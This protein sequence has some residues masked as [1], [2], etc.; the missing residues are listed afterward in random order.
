MEE[1]NPAQW[2]NDEARMLRHEAFMTEV[3]RRRVR[4][5]GEG[6]TKPWWQRFLE[7]TGGAAMI[8]VL[9]GGLLGQL[10]TWSV[11]KGLKERE[12]QEAW[13]KARGDQ[14]LV[15]YKDYLNQEQEIVRRVYEIVGSCI[16]VS[17]DLIDLT[18]LE[19]APGKSI[20]VEKQRNSIRERYNT[21]DAQWRGEREKLG[22]L[23]S[24][25]HR[26][27][28]EVAAAWRDLQDSVT[29]YNECAGNWYLDHPHPLIKVEVA[30][31]CKNDR[32]DLRKRLEQLSA[33]LEA[34]RQYA[35]E[36]WESPEKLRSALEREK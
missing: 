6:Y 10:I 15:T 8:T 34:S 19:F 1:P 24:Y 5:E 23:M 25:Y 18:K 22:L 20:G 14:A 27:R 12:F 7:S 31:A 2:S 28:P 26:G 9:I 30:D 3:M 11:Q 29:K 4:V 36:G 17:E 16:S 21:I 13:M 35:W 33:S 32:D